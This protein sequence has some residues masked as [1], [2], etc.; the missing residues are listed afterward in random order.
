M[1]ALENGHLSTTWQE[2]EPILRN[3]GLFHRNVIIAG[4]KSSEVMFA[5]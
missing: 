4:G 1:E 3:S 2:S 5:L